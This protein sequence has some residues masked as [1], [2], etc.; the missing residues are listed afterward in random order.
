MRKV[1]QYLSI[2]QVFESFC[3]ISSS[4]QTIKDF[5]FDDC[6]GLIYF[7]VNASN[8]VYSSLNDKGDVS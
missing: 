4:L 3:V 1:K 5:A 8:T 7:S 2:K 6:Q